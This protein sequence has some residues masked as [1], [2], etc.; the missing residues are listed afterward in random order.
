MAAT[1]AN[2]N[3]P[4][5]PI[6]EPDGASVLDTAVQDQASPIQNSNVLARFE[7]ESGRGN[8]G[9]KILMVEWQDDEESARQPGKWHVSWE[10]KPRAVLAVEDQVRQGIHRQYFLLLPGVTIP[11]TVTLMH[12]SASPSQAKNESHNMWQIKPLP[13][14]FPPELGGSARR[15]SKKGIL[16]TNWAKIRLSEL[17]R[18]IDSESR[19]NVEGVGLQI[20]LQEKEW[21]EQNFGI[22]GRTPGG[23]S[24]P[25]LIIGA[26]TQFPTAPLSPTTPVSPKTP[27]GTNRLAEKLKGLRVG[28]S[29]RELSRRPGE[30]NTT[31]S[32]R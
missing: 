1:T 28:T 9:T 23:L 14:I 32:L 18:E 21:I 2:S 6:F 16:H 15:H 13:A 12:K 29:E 27:G 7:F 5:R 26:D 8:E 31:S 4:T 24:I 17:Q 19:S 11:P 10:K 25:P 30:A 22:G 20:A 3:R